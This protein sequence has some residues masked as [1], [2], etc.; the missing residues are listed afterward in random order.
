MGNDRKG[1]ARGDV[2]DHMD[3][4]VKKGR[5]LLLSDF[6][7]TMTFKTVSFVHTG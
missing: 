3:V 1:D 4:D 5:L 2:M 6:V 7:I